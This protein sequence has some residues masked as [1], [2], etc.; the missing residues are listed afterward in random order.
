MPI[1]TLIVDDEK[2]GLEN[3]AELIKTHCPQIGGGRNTHLYL[4]IRNRS[5]NCLPNINKKPAG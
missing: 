5:K 3:L 2:N 1:S 4:R